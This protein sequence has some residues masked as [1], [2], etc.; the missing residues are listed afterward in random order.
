M[1]KTEIFT[2]VATHLI[3]QNAKASPVENDQGCAYRG[4]NGTMCAVGCLIPD[5][6]YDPL[7]EGKIVQALLGNQYKG[8]K[9]PDYF[10]EHQ[11][12][13]GDLQ[14]VHDC[15]NV[16]D[17]KIGLARVEMKHK[18]LSIGDNVWLL[19][20]IFAKAEKERVQS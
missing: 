3:K 10:E 18:V 1:N 13:L 20:D 17:W 19:L 16:G 14:F 12:L 4:V 6:M 5:E 7:M 9:V 15:M 2:T 11:E 8:Y